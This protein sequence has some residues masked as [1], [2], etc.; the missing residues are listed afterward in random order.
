MK[1]ISKIKTVI[2][3]IVSVI[4]T[5][6]ITIGLFGYAM[7]ADKLSA[8]GSVKRLEDNL[9]YME[10]KGDYGFEEFLNNGGASSERELALYLISFMSGGFWQGD[11]ADVS[12]DFGCSALTTETEKGTLMGRNFDWEGKDSAVMIIHTKPDNGYESYSTT[13]LDFL[14]FGEGF[15][16]ENFSEKY[17]AMAGVYVPLDGI[18]EKGLCVADLLAGDNDTTNQQTDKAV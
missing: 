2:L 7:F 1:K 14:G 8:A 10:Y 3:I 9:Y 6:T 11:P 13:W 17:M 18:N 4:L 5:A 12:L 15:E 16:P